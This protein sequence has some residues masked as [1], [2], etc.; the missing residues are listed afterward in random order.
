MTTESKTDTPEAGLPADISLV[1]G[2]LLHRL[3]V[4]LRLVDARHWN[5]GRR[6]LICVAIV[7]LPVV[8]IRVALDPGR[9]MQIVLDYRI[10]AR[11]LIAAP[12]L[13]LAGPI[14]DT[15]F[16]MLVEH[17][18]E[19]HLLVGHDL[20]K[21]YE[22]LA[23][24]QRLRD[25]ILPELFFLVVV[26][27]RVFL[28]Y[29]FIGEES[30]G[31]L[32]F[33]DPTGVRLTPAGWYAMVVSAPIVAFLALVVLWR[34]V[35]WTIF[36]FR[37]S[38]LNLQL[39][40]S[41]PDENGGLGF[42]SIST[43]AFVP[44]SFAI[45]TVIGASFRN[46]IL[47]GGKHLVNYRGPGIALAV[48][49]FAIAILP[50]LFF[51]PKLAPLRRKGILEYSIIGHMQS[52]AVHEKWVLH[53]E[54]NEPEVIAAPEFSTLCDYNSAYKNVEDM[55]PIP[56]DKEALVGLALSIAIPALPVILAEV[57]LQ[58]VLQALLSALK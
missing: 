27:A 8:L 55:Y 47:N 10:I 36:A 49:I 25:S 15:R 39:V 14:M 3:L 26:I 2:G 30:I 23:G 41:H 6:I 56:V 9:I 37:L 45:S 44:F 5:P 53:G 38:R 17:V 52:A 29:K 50:L 57:P 18:R 12:V 42:L 34:W 28:S 31:N 58:T 22:I 19:T 21:M 16:R 24:V 1:R 51:F 7:W 46:G 35:L 40:P 33:M 54:E 32:A 48:I 11:M 20:V 4:A 13:I 43:Q